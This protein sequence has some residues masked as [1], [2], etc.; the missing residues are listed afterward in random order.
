MFKRFSWKW[1]FVTNVTDVTRHF[2]R[3]SMREFSLA[4]V[5][6]RQERFSGF[7]GKHGVFWKSYVSQMPQM[8]QDIPR[9]FQEFNLQFMFLVWNPW[10]NVQHFVDPRV[11]CLARALFPIEHVE[12]SA[13]LTV[14]IFFYLIF[15][16]GKRA[17]PNSRAVHFFDLEMSSRILRAA[18]LEK[19]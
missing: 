18:S 2:Q 19:K 12:G 14:L 15:D 4:R 3:F 8:S 5:Q 7:S 17:A 13:L 6:M 16:L 10:H 1:N 11:A 9:D